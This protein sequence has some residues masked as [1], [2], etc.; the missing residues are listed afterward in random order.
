MISFT[1]KW[2]DQEGLWENKFP[3]PYFFLPSAKIE[4]SIGYIHSPLFNSEGEKGI[5]A[6]TC[7]RKK[8][9]MM[10][11]LLKMMRLVLDVR[12]TKYDDKMTTTIRRRRRTR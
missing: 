9:T 3:P 4:K 10:M 1:L 7:L 5:N 8:L 2:E 6:A 12:C 11:L